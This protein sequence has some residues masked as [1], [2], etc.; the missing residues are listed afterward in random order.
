MIKSRF[1][2]YLEL[3][4]WSLLFSSVFRFFELLYYLFLKVS[5][6][7]YYYYQ[8]WMAPVYT[9]IL[10]FTITF[11]SIIYCETVN[12]IKYNDKVPLRNQYINTAAAL[13]ILFY[14]LGIYNFKIAISYI[15]QT[16]AEA[17]FDPKPLVLYGNIIAV[18]VFLLIFQGVKKYLNSIIPGKTNFRFIVLSLLI[19]LFVFGFEK[20]T[21]RIDPNKY[22]FKFTS[23]ES[24]S[25]LNDENEHPNVI[26]LI[27]DTLRSDF[28]GC[29]GNTDNL[30]PNIDKIAAEGSVFLNNYANC[31]W[32]TGS[33]GSFYT[34]QSP[35]RI[36]YRHGKYGDDPIHL[37][38]I[39]NKVHEKV[40]TIPLV[41]DENGYFVCSFQANGLAGY[42][43]NF[44]LNSDFYM[45]CYNDRPS[46]S[47]VPLFF[48]YLSDF[49]NRILH[50]GS[51]FS[52]PQMDKTFTALGERLV[53]YNIGFIEKNSGA[54]C[55]VITNFMDV[56]DFST[57]QDKKYYDALKA[58]FTAEGRP[59]S[60]EK[61]N[62]M[63]NVT[64]VDHQIGRIYNY[65]K[66][67]GILDN[68]ILV[69]TSDH[70]E[71]LNEHGN[72]GHGWSLY[73]CEI[74]VP[75]IIRYP[76]KVP[77]NSE[78]EKTTSLLDLFPTLLYLCGISDENL[79]LEG[80]NLFSDEMHER[81]VY[82]G[83]TLYTDDMQSV[84]LDNNKLI[85]LDEYDEF[86]LHNLI[87]DPDETISLKW[88][89]YI[90]GKTMYDSLNQWRVE[91][92][93]AQSN[94][95]EAINFQSEEVSIDRQQLRALGYIK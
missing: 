11:V 94:L 14:V 44:H 81:Y 45:T 24:V 39:Y 91:M 69:I 92:M 31:P 64:Y 38:P 13:F 90:K 4:F 33:F 12:K 50:I 46:Y 76:A 52:A 86:H 83:F 73:D 89:D 78:Y 65:L 47:I 58:K 67:C 18:M 28:L 6:P 93:E 61:L 84:V 79:N 10:A 27:I 54:P 29:Y 15:I 42:K 19:C 37:W 40:N 23:N 16:G 5:N 53:D 63:T 82:S 85:H 68:T 72:I 3:L 49:S 88:E 25:E 8:P 41:F 59:V 43:Y 26:L 75:L 62:Y 2:I 32:T 1:I 57:R 87:S 48:G 35:Y 95:R 74:K 80:I 71:Q 17:D 70:G 9:W 20:I 55:I 22:Y 66:T 7:E 77:V 30:T 51:F 60:V 56:H 21:W 34:S 36:F